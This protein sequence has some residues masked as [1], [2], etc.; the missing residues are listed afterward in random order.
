MK[1]VIIVATLLGLFMIQLGCRSEGGGVDPKKRQE[2]I[3]I[4]VQ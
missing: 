3:N 4:D 2:R 1:R